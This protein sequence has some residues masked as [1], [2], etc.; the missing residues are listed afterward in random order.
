MYLWRVKGGG[1][2]PEHQQG[3][4]RKPGA[5]FQSCG[6]IPFQPL[7]HPVAIGLLGG[8]QG[9]QVAAQHRV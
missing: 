1:R 5:P 6:G 4:D 7:E 3:L 2:S 8:R 9:I